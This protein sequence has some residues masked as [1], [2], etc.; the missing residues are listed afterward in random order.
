MKKWEGR[1]MRGTS[2]VQSLG[3]QGEDEAYGEEKQ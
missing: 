3:S 1:P 2:L